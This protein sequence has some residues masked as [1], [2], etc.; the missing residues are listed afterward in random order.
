MFG[1]LLKRLREW[2][3]LPLGKRGERLA[4]KWL[5]KRGYKI[6]AKSV[7]ELGGEIDLVARQGPTWVFVEVKTRTTADL[8]EPWEAVGAVKEK[9]IAQAARLFLHRRKIR[10]V[11]TRFDVI[12]IVWPKEGASEPEVVHYPD[13]FQPSGI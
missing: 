4:A 12:S 10:E 9:R 11:P 2:R 6:V 7:K 5:T 3:T 13:A 8:G 1:S